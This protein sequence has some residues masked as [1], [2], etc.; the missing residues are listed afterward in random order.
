MNKKLVGF[1]FIFIALFMGAL[2]YSSTVQAPFI[3]AL[4]YIKS[5][6]H[7]STKWVQD[8]IHRYTFQASHI[9]E[10]QV[11]LQEY[12][13]NHLIMQQL[14]A[15]LGDLYDENNSTLKTDPKVQL[16]RALS[17]AKFGDTNKLWLEVHDYNDSKV[18]GLTY[19]EVV[20]GIVVSENKRALALLNKDIKSAYAVY[21]GENFAPGIV[22]GNNAKFLLV[23]FIPSWI[24]IKEGDEVVTSGLDQIFFKG[25]K[26]G[27]VISITK[28]QGY[29]N[30]MIEPYYQEND[31][32][33]FHMIKKVQ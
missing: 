12:K 7:K 19:K 24:E 26:V 25:L 2:Y 23:K 32:K 15:E 9:K 13:N 17:Y 29:Q 1:L 10:L 28:S 18:Y 11:A 30:A 5:S 21:V 14:A 3:T 31:P 33:Y 16:V 20:A 6:Y 4:N 22:H 27:K 8:G